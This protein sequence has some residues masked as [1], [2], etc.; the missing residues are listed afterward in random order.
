MIERLPLHIFDDE[1]D[2][3]EKIPA[4]VIEPAPDEQVDGQLSEI[5]PIDSTPVVLVRCQW[6]AEEFDDSLL[7]C[8]AC[9]VVH[10][11]AMPITDATAS[12]TTC[13]WCQATF[14]AGTETC[15]ECDAKIVVPGQFVIGQEDPGLSLLSR[16]LMAQRAQSHQLLVG[17]MAVGG[18]DSIT[19]G[20]IGLA[21]SL[22]DD[23]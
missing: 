8:P 14:E 16:S 11:I 5:A 23:D 12:T 13:Q 22:F 10:R 18:L 7:A 17:M 15:P 6:C 20:L 9:G 2:Q 3:P 1:P 19:G 4:A 21:L